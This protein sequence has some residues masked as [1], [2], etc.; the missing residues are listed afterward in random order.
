[1]RLANDKASTLYHCKPFMD[2]QPAQIVTGR[3]VWTARQGL[4]HGDIETTVQLAMDGS[5]NNVDV[6]GTSNNPVF[7]ICKLVG[8]IEQCGKLS[9]GCN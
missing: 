1:M 2:G 9:F 4:G 7:H 3:W 5:T 8:S 6:Q